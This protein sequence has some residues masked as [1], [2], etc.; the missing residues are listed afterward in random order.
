[1]S[2]PSGIGGW[3]GSLLIGSSLALLP[4]TS[5]FAADESIE[6]VVVTGSY[7]KRKDSFDQA[8]P[9]EVF[10][11]VDI[12]EEGTPQ[13]ADIFRNMTFNYGVETVSNAFAAFGQGGNDGT[14]NMRGL[15]QRSTLIL[16]NGRRSATDNV[17]NMYP[18]IAIQRIEVLKDGAAALYG[19]DA[20][21]GVVNI[22]P[23]TEFEGLELHSSYTDVEGYDELTWGVIGGAQS[24]ENRFMGAFEWRERTELRMVDRPEYLRNQFSYSSTGN[25]GSYVVP[26][27]AA[28]G[29]ISTQRSMPDPGCGLWN[30]TNTDKTQI[31]SFPS[32]GRQIGNTVLPSVSGSNCTF[33]FGQ[34]WNYIDPQE[35]FR[36]LFSFE[37]DFT[38]N[39]TFKAELS[40]NRMDVWQSRGSPSN[41]GGRTSEVGIIPGDN[42]GNPYL[43]YFDRNGDSVVDQTADPAT[44]EVLYA[45][46]T[47]N[48]AG[49]QRYV[50]DASGVPV[51][52][53]AA[54]PF[55]P[56]VPNSAPLKEDVRIAALRHVG[57]PQVDPA[58]APQCGRP[59]SLYDDGANTSAPRLENEF[60]W[61]GQIDFDI[62]NSTWS[63]FVS[64]TRHIDE[65]RLD[66]KEGSLS[67][68]IAGVNGNLIAPDVETTIS[69]PT[70]W[71]PFTTANWECD[72]L[73]VVGTRVACN[74]S[75]AV[76]T[77]P[78]QNNS[79]TE[80]DLIT[81]RRDNL[82]QTELDVAEAI[83]T[84][85]VT[86]M[87]AGPLSAAV[88]VQWRDAAYEENNGAV[89]NAG[90]LWIGGNNPDFR[91]RRDTIAYFAELAI[92]VLQGSAAGD[93]DIQL[94]VR[95]EDAGSSEL[96]ST[97]P[98]IAVRWQPI[99]WLALRATWGE[100]FIAPSL[101]DLAEP[102]TFGLT[103][104]ADPL[105]GVGQAFGPAAI[106]GNPNLKPEQSDAMTFGFTFSLLDGDLSFG[107][108][109]ID[110]DFTDRIVRPLPDEI[111]SDD[112]DNA[113]AFYG[114][115]SVATLTPA[116]IF[117][118]TVTN[119][120]T[121]NGEDTRIVREQ[122]V[123]GAQPG[124][125]YVESTWTNAQAVKFRG[126]D[127]N[128]SYGFNASQIP[129]VDADF[130]RFSIRYTGS[131]IDKYSVIAAPGEPEI[132]GVGKQNNGTGFIPPLPKWRTNLRIGWDWGNHNVAIIG[133]HTDSFLQDDPLPGLFAS[134]V[135]LDTE[136]DSHVEWDVQ[137]NLFLERL[138]G[139]RATRITIGAINIGDNRP[140]AGITRGG[141]ET[142]I[143]DIRG[144]QV[145]VRLQQEI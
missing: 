37:H 13:V 74:N 34:Y 105:L 1:M 7:I 101:T 67:Q 133:R 96:T 78:D 138:I 84:G 144:R 8:T 124:I 42:P 102:A 90:D 118:W 117:E 100:S 125:R 59:S 142:Q 24:D 82:F 43:A 63:G 81:F 45:L 57:K 119:K 58:C 88:G 71:N 137:Y 87:P 136:F 89:D 106:G 21:A 92:P 104:Y 70:W 46:V 72:S 50:R 80:W 30:G 15:G 19:S 83:V 94:A 103:Q 14:A 32:G 131:F 17:N 85:E 128:I 111:I 91:V 107:A 35:G 108:D 69:G 20:V 97:D 86:E 18:Q 2:N 64:Y 40:F 36:S 5:L 123:G 11:A 60:R 44:N 98:K 62:P 12:A 143:F 140:D 66:L 16:L 129:W 93:L 132:D 127:F 75:L 145:Y 95:R 38:D 31:G 141:T 33:E 49:Q 51:F 116:Q 68:I 110:I 27:R 139:D 79:Q 54:N 9:I 48:S 25:P 28:D 77:D 130:G 10:D 112:V 39:L 26:V 52:A 113:V 41:P 4:A 76:Q 23:K 120:G 126:G 6:E 56:T 109:F 22:I 114:A 3:A 47:T 134:F 65:I 55:D 135:E 122:V 29:S 73:S 99:E 121:A 61:T 115:T 53:N